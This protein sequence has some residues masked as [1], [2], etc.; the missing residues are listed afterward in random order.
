MNY[1]AHIFLS[2]NNHQLQIGNFIGDF[3]KGSRMNKYP[4]N[5][6]KGII[7]HRK[8]DEFTDNHLVVREAIG[9][10]KPEFGRYS[11]IVIDMYFDYFLAINF[12]KYASG[13][14]H[15]FAFRFYF[16]TLIYYK[17]LPIRVR[18]FIFH[19]IITHRLHK[20]ASVSGLRN[21]FQIMEKYKTPAIQ[22]DKT[23]QFLIENTDELEKQFHRF[24]PDLVEFVTSQ[25]LQIKELKA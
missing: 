3:V 23:I 14:L 4:E 2:G 19:F 24:F 12:R 15:L 7:L 17:H 9:L 6:R 5:I 13:S 1:L 25:N 18:G 22:P 16:Y 10:L 21:S 11:A 20:Y 8:I